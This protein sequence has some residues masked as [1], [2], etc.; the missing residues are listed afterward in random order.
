MS[1]YQRA[2]EKFCVALDLTG[3]ILIGLSNNAEGINGTL[4]GT[5]GLNVRAFTY[6][7]LGLDWCRMNAEDLKG[8]HHL[9]SLHTGDGNGDGH[10][11]GDGPTGTGADWKRTKAIEEFWVDCHQFSS[12]AKVDA[13]Q[14]NTPEDFKWSTTNSQ[15]HQLFPDLNIKLVKEIISTGGLLSSVEISETSKDYLTPDEWH[16]EM[17]Q[18]K[19]H[20]G[21]TSTSANVH[22]P[23]V[24]SSENKARD[25]ILIDCRNHKEYAIGHFEHSVDPNTKNFA[26]FPRWVKENKS[27]L[28]DKNIL[29]YCTVSLRGVIFFARFV[30]FLPFDGNPL[31]RM[32]WECS[33]LNLYITNIPRKVKLIVTDSIIIIIYVYIGWDSMRKGKC[34]YS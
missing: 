12:L 20:E 14:M 18:L 4:A 16:E 29:M 33:F 32:C 7:L 1:H 26:Q 28:K 5:D 21:A 2:I 11:H 19:A 22:V 27:S 9:P 34:L 13:P 24:G 31:S 10:G 8:I 6:A 23:V 30:P 3:R 25:T 17:K 15:E